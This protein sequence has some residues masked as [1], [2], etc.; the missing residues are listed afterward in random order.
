MPSTQTLLNAYGRI[1]IPN[2][3][4]EMTFQEAFDRELDR[5][6]IRQA[7]LRLY[8][9]DTKTIQEAFGEI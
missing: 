6:S 5:Y 4:D 2:R 8:N 9:R 3:I 7:M 1:P